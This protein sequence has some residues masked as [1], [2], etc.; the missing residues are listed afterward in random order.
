VLGL[1]VPRALVVL[2]AVSAAHHGRAIFLANCV[3]RRGFVW[4]VGPYVGLV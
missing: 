2:G 1:G 3:P 4:Y